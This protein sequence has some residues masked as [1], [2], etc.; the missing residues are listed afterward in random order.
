MILELHGLE[1][2]GRHGVDEHERRDGQTFFVDVTLHVAEPGEDRI[3]ATYDYRRAR[4]LVRA[5]NE[6]ASYR[7]LETFAAAVADALAAEPGIEQASVR[8]RKPGVEWAEWTA[9]S[10]ERP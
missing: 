5:V 1:L 10:V 8:I 3:D 9:A 2:F 7:L 4:D 6:R